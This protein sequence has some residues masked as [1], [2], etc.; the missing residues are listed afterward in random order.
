MMSKSSQ[1]KQFEKLSAKDKDLTMFTITKLSLNEEGNLV[2]MALKLKRK[3]ATELLTTYLPTVLLLLITYTTVFFDKDLF[4]DAIAVNLTIMLVMT[5]IFTSK[6][7]E[8]PPTSDMK[9]ID[10]WLIFCLVVPFTEVILRTM[11]ESLTCVC[12]SDEETEKENK[13]FA[14]HVRTANKGKRES[15]EEEAATV[16]VGTATKVAPKQV[17][18]NSIVSHF[19]FFPTHSIKA[20]SAIDKF[21]PPGWQK[22]CEGTKGL[23]Q[24]VWT[25]T[26]IALDSNGSPDLLLS[27]LLTMWKEEGIRRR[28]WENV[29]RKAN[30]Q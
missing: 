12:C 18:E 13:T 10:L 3:V 27:T 20:P 1:P 4:G 11:I 8:L 26:K 24:K 30:W 6:I 9:M 17:V 23:R 21:P 15:S 19:Y 29:C 28:L 5:T 16:W 22:L 2:F 7:E 14:D 25:R